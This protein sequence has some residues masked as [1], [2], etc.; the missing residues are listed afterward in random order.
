MC[1]M[2]IERLQQSV[3]TTAFQIAAKESVRQ[4]GTTIP[5]E[6]CTKEGYLVSD[7]DPSERGFELEC[8]ERR[9]TAFDP[10]QIG[11]MQIAMTLAYPALCGTSCHGRAIPPQCTPERVT[12]FM[13]RCGGLAG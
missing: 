13:Q 2:E 5:L 3:V 6:I 10:H 4:V 1:E 12:Q 7:V 8:V 9:H 11:K